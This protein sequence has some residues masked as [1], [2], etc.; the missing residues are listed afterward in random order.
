[1]HLNWTEF[2]QPR[3]AQT[4]VNSQGNSSSRSPHPQ[5]FIR[6]FPFLFLGLVCL[7]GFLTPLK[8]FD[9]YLPLQVLALSVCTAS[10]SSTLNKGFGSSAERL[11]SHQTGGRTQS[12]VPP[13]T[14]LR[15][16]PS[17]SLVLSDSLPIVQGLPSHLRQTVKSMQTCLMALMQQEWDLDCF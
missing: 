3:Y 1:M 12:W 8:V 14:W 4:K 2:S 6:P 11:S 17:R 13:K 5:G 15:E 16:V 9:P 10:Q 7:F